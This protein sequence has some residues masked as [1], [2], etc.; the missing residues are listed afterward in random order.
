MAVGS[1][2]FNRNDRTCP[3]STKS[4]TSCTAIGKNLTSGCRQFLINSK[5]RNGLLS[6]A[7]TD[8][9]VGNR[10]VDYGCRNR[11]KNWLSRLNEQPNRCY[12]WSEKSATCPICKSDAT[13]DGNQNS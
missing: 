7:N 2:L 13:K 11:S 5:K 4:M 9:Y 6:H 12:S 1:Y 10:T 8:Q 3:L